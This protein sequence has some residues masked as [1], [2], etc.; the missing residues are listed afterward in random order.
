MTTKKEY[1]DMVELAHQYEHAYWCED[2]PIVSDT[3][4]DKL[5]RAI[6][7]IEKANPSFVRLDSPSQRIG[8][9]CIPGFVTVK[10]KAPML[11]LENCF[12]TDDL[13][14]WLKTTAGWVPDS[15]VL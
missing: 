8:G 4:F 7:D 1:D 2:K 13:E 12:S 14:K 10:H 3:E 5:C 6:K 9:G 11:S 15:W